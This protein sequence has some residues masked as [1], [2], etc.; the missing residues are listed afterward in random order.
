[1]PFV[2]CADIIKDVV[3]SL[4]NICRLLLCWCRSCTASAKNC[5]GCCNCQQPTVVLTAPVVFVCRSFDTKAGE[6]HDVQLPFEEFIP[7]FRAKTVKGGPKLD[8]STVTSIQVSN[9]ATQQQ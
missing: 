8:P 7:L 1:M 2:A 5:A 4:S 6:W 3:C 9:N